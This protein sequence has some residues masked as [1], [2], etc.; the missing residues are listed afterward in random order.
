[1]GY[2]QRSID[3][4]K[5]IPDHVQLCLSRAFDTLHDVVPVWN[6]AHVSDRSPLFITC[7]G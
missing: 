2:S 1:M 5:D 3:V 7:F 6:A 4:R